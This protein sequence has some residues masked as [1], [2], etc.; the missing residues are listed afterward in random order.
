VATYSTQDVEVRNGQ[1]KIAVGDLLLLKNSV[2]DL[3]AVMNAIVT[4]LT[5]LNTKTGPDVSAAITLAQTQ[6]TSLLKS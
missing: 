6:I 3:L 1:S 2:T 4:A 5:A